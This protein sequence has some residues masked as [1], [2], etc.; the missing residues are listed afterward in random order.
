MILF[1]DS[2]KNTG[3]VHTLRVEDASKKEDLHSRMTSCLAVWSTRKLGRC[4]VY[5][6]FLRSY[7]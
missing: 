4:M 6:G 2:F 3:T 7:G 5:I 1:K